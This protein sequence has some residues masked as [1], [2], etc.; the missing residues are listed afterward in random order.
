VSVIGGQNLSNFIYISVML[1][2]LFTGELMKFLEALVSVVK[3]LM[4]ESTVHRS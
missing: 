2:K 1:N 3:C 4:G